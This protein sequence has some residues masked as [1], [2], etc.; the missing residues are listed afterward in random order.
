MEW[1]T[2]TENVPQ[3]I[4]TNQHKT[5]KEKF[6]DRIINHIL[7]KF[8]CIS[9]LEDKVLKRPTVEAKVQQRIDQAIQG[10]T[11]VGARVHEKEY[12]MLQVQNGIME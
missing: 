5:T 4:I 10:A 3:N 11:I 7:V 12:R 6:V 2:L 9:I 8:D 1:I